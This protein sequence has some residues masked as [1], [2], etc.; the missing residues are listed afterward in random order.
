MADGMRVPR[1]GVWHL[2]SKK[3]PRWN[4]EGQYSSLLGEPPFETPTEAQ[5]A[6]EELRST[7]GSGP[8]DDLEAISLPYPRPQLKR[9]FDFNAFAITERQVA[10]HQLTRKDDLSVGFDI[11]AAE[12]CLGKPGQAPVYRLPAQFLG[13]L[14]PDPGAWQ[15][16]WVCEEKGSLGPAALKS[17]Q[18]VREYGKQHDIP[19]L[20]YAEITL[21]TAD[22][23]PWFNGDYLAMIST[24]ICH[25]DFYI[26][27]P[28]PHAPELVMYWVI[29]APQVPAQPM[30]ES[31]RMASAISQ[32]MAA[33]ANAIGGTSGREI[34]RAYANVKGCRIAEI[35]ERRLQI[36][37]PSG[38]PLFVDFDE[39]GAIYGLELPAERQEPKKS[40]WLNRLFSGR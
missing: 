6:V 27:G 7:L 26:S 25:A 40:S 4:R 10:L 32:T 12:V 18:M 14:S 22:D 36:D 1:S 34:I 13:F 2:R 24:H 23:R 28:V 19:E 15:W 16:G 5:E 31:R 9:L 29:K 17:V 11:R 8:P 38:G 30:S 3:D 20:S 39:S 33:W 35:G 37:P 21:G